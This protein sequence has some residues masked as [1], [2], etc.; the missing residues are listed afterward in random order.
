MV[1]N[2]YRSMHH[3]SDAGI[4]LNVYGVLHFGEYASYTPLLVASRGRLK[5]QAAVEKG[6]CLLF[7][8]LAPVR[9]R[10][11]LSDKAAVL[12]STNGRYYYYNILTIQLLQ[13][14]HGEQKRSTPIKQQQ[15]NS[16]IIENSKKGR[17]CLPSATGPP[18]IPARTHKCL[19]T[20][21]QFRHHLQ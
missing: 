1:V 7:L 21:F 15:K 12:N 20:G 17:V 19:P 14:R 11:S 18:E 10:S 8:L 9:R 6:C 16:I 4:S 2:T 13:S 3:A 5:R